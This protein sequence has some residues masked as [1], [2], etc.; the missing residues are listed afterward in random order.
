[1]TQI[2][3][4]SIKIIRKWLLRLKIFFACGALKGASGGSAQNRLP[5]PS[6]SSPSVRQWELEPGV[7]IDILDTERTGVPKVTTPLARNG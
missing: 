7:V 3:Q 1:M 5:W 6:P 4:K 2:N